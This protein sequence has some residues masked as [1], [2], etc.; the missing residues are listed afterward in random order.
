MIDI[1]LIFS[2]FQVLLHTY[3]AI[4]RTKFLLVLFYDYLRE[5]KREVKTI[6]KS[7]VEDTANMAT[8]KLESVKKY[9][10]V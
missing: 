2:L 7:K 6:E 5:D 9:S 3:K 1:W 4:Y 10:N 8:K